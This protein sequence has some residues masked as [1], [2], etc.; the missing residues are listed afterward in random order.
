M[1]RES[2][3]NDN[4]GAKATKGVKVAL[5]VVGMVQ[6]TVNSPIVVGLTEF[7]KWIGSVASKK[8]K[9]EAERLNK[10]AKQLQAAI[11]ALGIVQAKGQQEELDRILAIQ[12]KNE[13][14][15][16]QNIIK[17]VAISSVT[18]LIGAGIILIIKKKNSQQPQ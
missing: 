12:K 5:E 4:A 14:I 1:L 11:K 2:W 16:K 13:E 10:K 7:G 18:L 3:H 9:E 15:K 6:K 17:I 8:N